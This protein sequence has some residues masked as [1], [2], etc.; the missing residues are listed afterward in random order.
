MDQRLEDA[1]LIAAAVELI[2]QSRLAAACHILMT[3]P[4]EDPLRTESRFAGLSAVDR[5]PRAKAEPI[6]N[7]TRAAVYRRDGWRCRYCGRKV[8]VPIVLEILR[9]LCPHFKGLL[10]GHHMPAGDTAP[11][12]E[13]VYPNVDHIHAVALGGSWRDPANHVTACTPCNTRKSDLLGWTPGPIVVDE[14]DGLAR[15]CRVLAERCD[16]DRRYSTWLRALGV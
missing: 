12:V 14:W 16:G 15:H 3:L 5:P 2:I 6:D 13:R 8:V 7:S 10:P 11:A 9:R 1:D 4:T